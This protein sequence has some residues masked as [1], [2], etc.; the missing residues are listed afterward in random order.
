METYPNEIWFQFFIYLSRFIDKQ[1][2]KNGGHSAQVAYWVK[3]TARKFNVDDVD[4]QTMFYA[5]LLH[6]IGKIGVPEDVLVKPGPLSDEEWMFM[7]L[8]P[9][10]G[11]NI[12]RQLDNTAHIAPTINAHQEKYDGTGYPK[13]LKGY[14]IPLGARI[15][16]VADAY[17][18]MT[19]GRIYRDAWTHNEASIELRKC[20]GT[21][22]DP[23]VVDKFLEVVDGEVNSTQLNDTTYNSSIYQ[24]PFGRLN[25]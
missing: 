16:A 23:A 21:Q 17:Q 8:H 18:A 13:G 14:E 7:R 1:I 5:A 25:M 4:E 22:F 6:D 20:K 15:L 11:A 9:I 24:Y 10:I 2:S 3:S 19:E 12:V